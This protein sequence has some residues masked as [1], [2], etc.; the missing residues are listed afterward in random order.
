MYYFYKLL[1]RSAQT[2]TDKWNTGIHTKGKDFLNH[3]PAPFKGGR[4]AQ[5][6]NE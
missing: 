6:A 4:M 5:I 1:F 3:P 2:P